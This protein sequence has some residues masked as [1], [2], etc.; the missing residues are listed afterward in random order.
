MT[1]LAKVKLLS[2]AYGEIK[3]DSTEEAFSTFVA[4][5]YRNAVFTPTVKA[6]IES[7]GWISGEWP[8]MKKAL[9][10]LNEADYQELLTILENTPVSLEVKKVRL[11]TGSDPYSKP[12][13]QQY[14]MAEQ[15]L[16]AGKF[17]ALYESIQGD[18]EDAPDLPEPTVENAALLL[19]FKELK[20]K[21][22][23]QRF[24]FG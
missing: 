8:G 23:T 15:V 3:S 19:R 17:E 16:A 20:Q 12:T 14:E 5:Q 11:G 13:K 6:I 2:P 9:E 7:K 1:R 21:E 10:S 24:I 22:E 18:W 4:N